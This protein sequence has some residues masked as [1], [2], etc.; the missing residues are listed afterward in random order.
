MIGKG[1]DEGRP[2]GKSGRRG[3][4][5]EVE[6]RFPNRPCGGRLVTRSHVTGD[7]KGRPYGERGWRGMMLEGEGWFVNRLYGGKTELVERV[8]SVTGDD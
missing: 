2:Y 3:M 1:D 4:M 8:E 6:G 5:L 7:H